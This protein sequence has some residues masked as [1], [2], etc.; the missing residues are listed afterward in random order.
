MLRDQNLSE[1]I[2]ADSFLMAKGARLGRN[3]IYGAEKVSGTVGS[4]SSSRDGIRQV[5]HVPGMLLQCP[6]L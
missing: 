6:A 1:A 4:S 5:S 3:I 2:K